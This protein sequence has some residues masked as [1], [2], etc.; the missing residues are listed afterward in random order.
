MGAETVLKA[1]NLKRYYDVKGGMFSKGGTVK[2]LD[3]ATFQLE[4]GKTLAVVGESGC[5]KSTLA[6]LVTLIEKPTEGELI[7]GG[8]DIASA[9]SKED[10]ITLRQMVQ[11]VFQDP[12]GSLNPRQKI[13]D[14][15]AEPLKIN[16]KMSASERR[17][18]VLSMMSRVGLRP[19]QADRYPH[20]FSGGQRQRIAVARALMLRPKIVI[21]DEPVSALDVSIQAQVLNLLTDLQEEMDL[22]YLF[23]S[24]DLSVVKH[25]ADDVLVMYLGQPVEHGTRD[26]IFS[27]PQHPYTRALLSATPV[28]DPNRKKERIKLVGELPSPL[29]PPSG[30]SFHPR[31]PLANDRCKVERPVLSPTSSAQVSC[32]AVEEGRS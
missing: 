1:D 23:I 19:E 25:I 16:T 32:H 31:C 24:H 8:M 9:H 14:I 18:A 3:G 26:E 15:L 10:M 2:A 4:A 29:N 30:C 28:A 5:G 7:L 11:I 17:E 21:L 12:Y 22:A 13:S 6:R 27:N 20:M